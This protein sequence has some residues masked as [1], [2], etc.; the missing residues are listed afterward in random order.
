MKISLKLLLLA[1][2]SS[3]FLLVSCNDDSNDPSDDKNK[4]Y[5][6]WTR[7]VTEFD[8][9]SFA[10]RLVIKE[11]NTFEFIVVDN[12]PGH[13]NSSATFH[14][15]DGTMEIIEDPDCESVG[16]YSYNVVEDK[17]TLILVIDDCTA[18]SKALS[19]VWNEYED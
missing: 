9:T 4:I 2:I 10:A 3:A 5:D 8:D 7:F 15:S 11:N 13:S 14:L 17:L 1:F 18:R 12:V 19:G 16:T 6:T